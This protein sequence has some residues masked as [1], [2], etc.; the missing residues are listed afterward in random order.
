MTLRAREQD[1]FN[2]DDSW[3]RFG[4][5]QNIDKQ[6]LP[7]LG[8]P[9][10]VNR[11]EAFID[12][13][14][15]RYFNNVRVNGIL[16]RSDKAYSLW[17]LLALLNSRPLDFFFKRI[18]KPKDRDYFEA[19]KQFIAPLPIP[20]TTDQKPLA[21]IARKLSDLYGKRFDAAARVHRRLATDLPPRELLAES[22]LPPSLPEKLRAFEHGPLPPLLDALEKFAKRKFKPRERADWDEYL[23]EQRT[24]LASVASHIRDLE[25][26]LN[27]RA[28]A[29]YGLSSDDVAFIRDH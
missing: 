17:F 1:R 20:K 22:P 25:Q 3:W 19:N 10:T 26:E 13:K 28:F 21:D 16:A 11:L 15:E 6:E 2:Q 23:T 27:D 14:G 12:P 7:K 18:A 8:V 24:K 5:P 4:R 9:Q 29:L